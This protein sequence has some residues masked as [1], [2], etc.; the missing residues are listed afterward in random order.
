MANENL[1]KPKS[2]KDDEFFTQ[3]SD[4]QNEVKIG[5]AHV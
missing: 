2:A 3:Y 1:K 4:I 5:R